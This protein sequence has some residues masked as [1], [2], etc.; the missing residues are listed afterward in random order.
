MMLPNASTPT[1]YRELCDDP[2]KNPLGQGPALIKEITSIYR[3]WKTDN[4]GHGNQLQILEEITL[5]MA[6]GMIGGI[7]VFTEGDHPGGTLHVL[8]GIRRH[9]L[10]GPHYGKYFA[11]VDDIEGIDA[12]VVEV[13]DMLMAPTAAIGTDTVDQQLALL[14]ADGDTYLVPSGAAA[15]RRQVSTRYSMFIPAP[16]LPLVLGHDLTAREALFVLVPAIRSL[17]LEEACAPL[18]DYLL[19]ATTAVAVD[20][21][22]DAPVDKDLAKPETV[23]AV[24]GT[25]PPLMS[26]VFHARR[27]EVM[28][29]DLPILEPSTQASRDPALVGVI[30]DMRNDRIQDL[31]DRRLER[32]EKVAPKTIAQKWNEKTV[33][34]LCKMCCVADEE[35]LPQLYHDLASHK[36][37]SD[38]TVRSLFQDAVETAA[39][40]LK[41]RYP[42][43][44]VQHATS[45]N[46]WSFCG[47]VEQ[48]LGEGLLPFSITPPDQ[49][50]AAAVAQLQANHYQNR[51]YSALMTGSTSITA[52]DAKAMRTS[53]G[54]IPVD[55]EEAEVQLESYTPVLGAL[56]GET[57]PNVLEHLA[58][59]TAL[60]TY[61]AQLRQFVSAKVGP[62]L[63]APTM[64]YYFHLKHRNWFSDQWRMATV[65]TLAPPTLMHAFTMFRDGYNLSWLPH[66][67]HVPL[68]L[69]L[70]PAP[71]PTPAQTPAGG[72]APQ[73]AGGPAD[74]PNHVRVRNSNRDSRVMGETPLGKRIREKSIPEAL[75]A[76]GG[77]PETGGTPRC[78]SWHLKGSCFTDCI[79][80]KDHIVL[81]TIDAHHLVTWCEEAY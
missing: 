1:N 21:D 27:R 37:A 36:K 32:E 33:D 35:L 74:N 50:S 58:A 16:L 45:L 30:K 77:P 64:V 66:T 13:S 28:Y 71:A 80:V 78:L 59:V 47:G 81:E 25:T 41:V 5:D 65:S 69:R 61:R 48:D 12:E 43:M 15:D 44:T 4:E 51:D 73:A 38:G 70:K 79:R 76:M 17:G 18:L 34:R 8:H 10:R 75:K 6:S 56:L 57:H 24:V 14:T 9:N 19:V 46:D 39:G 72:R 55:W 49:V 40:N 60:R 54:F 7:G 63:S 11:Y 62:R 20:D 52:A 67:D 23:Q 3:G 42:T 2:A 53:K 26:A 31:A 22:A 29:R 68:L